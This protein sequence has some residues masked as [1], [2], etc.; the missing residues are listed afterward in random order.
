MAK[1]LNNTWVETPTAS[2]VVDSIVQ[3]P[4]GTPVNAATTT[5]VNEIIPQTPDV[6]VPDATAVPEVT[7]TAIG[8]SDNVI[9]TSSNI[10]ATAQQEIQS[11]KDLTA[12]LGAIDQSQLE[13]KVSNAQSNFN[14]SQQIQTTQMIQKT[15]NELEYQKKLQEETDANVAAAKITQAAENELNAATAAEM[16]LKADNAE[17]EATIAND[18]ASQ[19][20]AIAFAKLGLSFSWAAIN[21]SQSIYA[22]WARN[23]AELKST[24]AKN[25][26]DLQ[27]KISRVEF[28]H[29]MSINSIISDANEKQF[30]SKERLREF[31]GNAQNNILLS[32]KESQAQIQDAITTYKSEAQTRED[33]LYTD[34]QSANATVLASTKEIQTQVTLQETNAR[35]QI[36]LLIKNGQ[37]GGLSNEKKVELEKAA[38]VP[39]GTSARTSTLFV[40]QTINSTLKEMAWKDVSVP[41]D[42][43]NKMNADVAWYQE[44]GYPLAT[45]TRIVIDKYKN[46]IPDYTQAKA[47]GEM[48]AKLTAAK[49]QAE[50]DK[51]TSE[52]KQNYSEIDIAKA[53]L[54]IARSSAASAWASA[55]STKAAGFTTKEWKPLLIDKSWVPYTLDWKVYGLWQNE[56][57]KKIPW[58]PIELWTNT[59]WATPS[60]WTSTSWDGM[61]DEDFKAALDKTKNLTTW[62]Q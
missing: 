9:A 25:Y 51:L 8:A 50:I 39:A 10:A 18:V 54:A 46:I 56:T 30:S 34:M 38:N 42:I 15:Q 5:P 12:K 35:S 6:S 11:Q 3:N 49:T 37:W 7:K 41:L 47:A 32:K 29:Q 40:N 20:S 28:D 33:K 19:S 53:K 27:V 21:T 4:D 44:K 26:A 36:D 14:E 55:N 43:L 1:E 61:S 45:A 31:I 16:K 52:A 23:I 2:P 59:T 58:D 22:Q 60:T 57:I 62:Q 48:K 17:R 24:N 13:T